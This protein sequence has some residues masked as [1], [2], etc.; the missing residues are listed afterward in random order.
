[1]PTIAIKPT[2]PARILDAY[3]RHKPHLRL[4]IAAHRAA[5]DDRRIA[6]AMALNMSLSTVPPDVSPR[7]HYEHVVLVYSRLIDVIA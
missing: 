7:E 2:F 3:G 6:H 1:M 4:L 5:P